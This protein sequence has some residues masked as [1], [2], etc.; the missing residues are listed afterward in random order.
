MKALNVLYVSLKEAQSISD[1]TYIQEAIDELLE[2]ESD[3]DKYLD[4]TTNGKCSKS[5]GSCLQSIKT[6][7]DITVDEIV[8]YELNTKPFCESTITYETCTKEDH[9]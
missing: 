6:A 2:Y 7:H 9:F 3:M 1:R 4:Y 5:V 8:K